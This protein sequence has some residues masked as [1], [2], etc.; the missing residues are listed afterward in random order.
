MI[1]S[2]FI[3]QIFCSKLDS[4]Q[5][6]IVTIIFFA[7]GLNPFINSDITLVNKIN[8]T[9]QE[10]NIF[11]NLSCIRHDVDPCAYLTNGAFANALV[12]ELNS[13]VNGCPPP[14]ECGPN[15]CCISSTNIGEF[16]TTYTLSGLNPWI[17]CSSRT[18]CDPYDCGDLGTMCNYADEDLQ[19]FMLTTARSYAIAHKPGCAT[20]I[21][22]MYFYIYSHGSE[23]TIEDCFNYEIYFHVEYYSCNCE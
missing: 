19:D 20:Y 2:K 1:L 17:Y 15:Q 8:N 13:L 23:C 4:R 6:T 22:N 18:D 21:R 7:I 11:P 5:F 3:R 10:I 16:Y 12:A 9:K 14:Q